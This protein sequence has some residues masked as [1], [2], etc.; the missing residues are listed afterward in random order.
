MR[1]K[2]QD[3]VSIIITKL[4]YQQGPSLIILLKADQDYEINLNFANLLLS[5][6]LHLRM[7]IIESFCLIS[8]K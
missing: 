8:R 5:L 2:A 7:R 1:N 3:S 4:D 6:A